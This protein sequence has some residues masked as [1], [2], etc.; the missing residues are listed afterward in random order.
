MGIL[1][2]LDF[3]GLSGG[4]HLLPRFHMCRKGSNQFLLYAVEGAR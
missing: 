1:D 3:R 4:S 2:M